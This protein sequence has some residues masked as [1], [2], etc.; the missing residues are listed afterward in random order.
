MR[1]MY[2]VKSAHAGPPTPE[3]LEAVSFEGGVVPP[4][5]CHPLGLKIDKGLAKP[6]RV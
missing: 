1:F 5:H 3:L 2:I 6:R 4:V